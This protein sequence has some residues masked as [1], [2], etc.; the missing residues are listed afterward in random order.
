MRTILEEGVTPDAMTKHAGALIILFDVLSQNAQ[1]K[2]LKKVTDKEVV[3]GLRMN[4][5]KVQCERLIVA[6]LRKLLAGYDIEA[7]HENKELRI[8]RAATKKRSKPAESA[9][10]EA[11]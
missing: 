7:N 8:T 5:Q 1:N 10:V 4:L 2:H 3:V 9:G 6:P 11:A